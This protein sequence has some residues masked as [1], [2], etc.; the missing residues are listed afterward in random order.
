[1]TEHR[2]DDLTSTEVTLVLHV[3]PTPRARGAQREAR[4][5]ADQLDVPGTRHHRVLTLFAGLPE[6]VVDASLDHPGGDSP[7]V[8][9]DPRLALRLRAALD[10]MDPDVVVAHGGEPL[11]YLVAAMIGRRRSLVYYAIGTYS[12]SHRSTQ[13]YLWRRLL[14]R[15]DAV[16][17][18]GEEVRD[19]CIARL[20]VPPRQV[21]VAPNGRDPEVFHP[22]DGTPGSE[23][24][25]VTFVGALTEGKGP[26]RF[27]DV[28][29]ALRARGAPLTAVV[30]GD[31]PLRQALAGPARTA[32]VELLGPRGDIADQLRRTDVMVFPSRPAG[33]GMP[34]VLIEAG[35]SGVAVVATSVPGVA[36]IVKDGE[37]GFVVPVDDVTEMVAAVTRLLDD[38]DL[39]SSMGRAARLH[40]LDNFSMDVVGQRWMRI[41]EP[42]LAD[43]DTGQKVR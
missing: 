36:S 21:T 9:F 3:I 14:A 30:I 20:G 29:G 13:L 27:I 35:L 5:L 16:A 33:E 41:L 18:E 17:A 32:G 10:R 22:Q 42:V 15:A 12:G 1:M 28:V 24:P 37:T 38:A 34:G 26:D 31:G 8:G 23:P 11:K 39:R 4:A 43:A 25:R 6:V 19:E 7:A 40:C 2:T